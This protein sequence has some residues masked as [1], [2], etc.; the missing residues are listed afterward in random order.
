MKLRDLR[1]EGFGRLAERR[2]VFDESFNVVYGPNEAGKSTLTA[3][4]VASLYG[5][6]RNER[7]LW[8]PWAGGRYATTLRYTLSDGRTFEIQRDFERDPKGVRVYDE[9]GN[10]VSAEL[11]VGKIINPGHAHLKIPLEVFMN[12]ACVAQTGAEIDGARAERISTALAHALDGGPR[13][14]AALGALRRLDEALAN[15]VGTKRATINA[16]LRRLQEEIAAAETVGDEARAHMRDVQNLRQRMDTETANAQELEQAVREHDAQ[17]RARRAYALRSRLEALK[18]V[19]DNVAALHYER[20]QYEDVADFPRGA[21]AQLEALYRDWQMAETLAATA[22][23]AATETRMSAALEVEFAERMADGGSLDDRAFEDLEQAVKEA[24]NARVAAT[25]ASNEVHAAR[26]SIEGG[27][28]LFGAAFA[29]G[30]I[31]ALAAVVLSIIH[32]WVWAVPVGAFAATMLGFAWW[33][34]SK[35]RTALR[36]IA[37]MQSAADAAIAAEGSAAAQIA[38]T[39]EPRGVTSFEEFVRRRDRASTLLERRQIAQ[40]NQDRAATARSAALAAGAAFDA[41]AST[42]IAPTGFRDAD[43]EAIRT[44]ET[45][46]SAR[47]GIELQLSMLDFNRR[48]ILGE[49]DEFS[50]ESELAELRGDGVAPLPIDRPQREYDAE[51][52]DLERRCSESRSLAAAYTAEL[53]GAEQRL[54]DLAALDER[55]GRLRAERDRL[56]SF[57]AAVALARRYIDERTREAHQKFARRLTDY[58]SRTIDG[59]TGGRY[60]DVRVDPTTLAVRVRAPETGAIVDVDRLS[61]GTREQ[62]YL[63]VRLAMVRMFSEGMETAPLLLDDPFAHWDEDRIARSFSVLDGGSP[64]VQTILFTTQ[65]LVADAATA[66]GARRID[67][68]DPVADDPAAE[69]D[70]ALSES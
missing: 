53:R 14:D 49:D 42:L 26:R 16:P 46:R 24:S 34:G 3:A 61:A 63:V 36:V 11:T 56:A 13:E 38:A 4:L 28:E 29:A 1:I 41:L 64:D 62:A 54:G 67:L 58:A 10:D 27:N 9:S 22:A 6:P 65:R 19:R 47:E 33:R 68:D 57:E 40:R 31:I 48:H 23:D 17:S 7:D 45:R 60:V 18:E 35:R 55:I 51:R 32:E 37:R 69:E 70:A 8:R 66:R 5:L 21:A 2:L 44:R 52:A 25:F 59:I 12:A 30:C 39:L 50:L 20:A 15:H 43:M